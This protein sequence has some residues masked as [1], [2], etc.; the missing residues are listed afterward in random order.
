MFRVLSRILASSSTPMD[1]TARDSMPNSPADTWGLDDRFVPDTQGQVLEVIQ[2]RT[3]RFDSAAQVTFARDCA[4]TEAARVIG[5][6]ERAVLR[7]LPRGSQPDYKVSGQF[8]PDLRIP[9]WMENT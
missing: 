5:L 4:V 3:T 1:A 7:K 8:G 2:D 6:S 9:T